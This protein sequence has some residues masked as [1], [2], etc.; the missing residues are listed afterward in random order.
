LSLPTHDFGFL[1]MRR[2]DTSSRVFNILQ[3]SPFYP[4]TAINLNQ[5]SRS[6]NASGPARTEKGAF[7]CP[8]AAMLNPD[9]YLFMPTTVYGEAAVRPIEWQSQGLGDTEGL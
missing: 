3:N 5:E 2:K 4:Q 6:Q 1:T 8:R 9:Y 7:P